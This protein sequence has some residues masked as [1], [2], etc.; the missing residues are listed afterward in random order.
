ML[1]NFYTDSLH[2]K[3]KDL[4][5][6]NGAFCKKQRKQSVVKV[7]LELKMFHSE[8]NIKIILIYNHQII[9]V[10]YLLF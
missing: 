8:F 2:F 1:F 9:I 6:S 4:R 3:E 10:N 5:N 7:F